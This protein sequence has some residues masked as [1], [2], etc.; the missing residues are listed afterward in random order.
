MRARATAG[1]GADLRAATSAPR[2]PHHAPG[3]FGRCLRVQGT[4]EHRHHCLMLG[5]ARILSSDWCKLENRLH[6][7]CIAFAQELASVPRHG[8]AWSL[9]SLE[10]ANG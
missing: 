7:E 8:P 5:P 9:G 10:E 6:I 2:P 3:T 4:A 1:Q